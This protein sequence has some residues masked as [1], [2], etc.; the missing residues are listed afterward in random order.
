MVL[1]WLIQMVQVSPQSLSNS[2]WALA[3]NEQ[4]S[5]EFFEQV[6]SPKLPKGYFLGIHLPKCIY[7]QCISVYHNVAICIFMRFLIFYKIPRGW[8][9]EQSKDNLLARM[10][11]HNKSVAS[12]SEVGPTG[13]CSVWANL[14]QAAAGCTRKRNYQVLV[15]GC[16]LNSNLSCGFLRFWPEGLIKFFEQTHLAV[17]FAKIPAAK[18]TNKTHEIK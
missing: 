15:L 8:Q 18:G 3:R 11:R 13:V 2:L 16:L 6:L 4:R 9:M 12:E 1:K 5:P 10:N 14:C 7:A 17:E